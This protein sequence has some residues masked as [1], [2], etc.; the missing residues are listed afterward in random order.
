MRVSRAKA[1]DAMHVDL[2]SAKEWSGG[3]VR[4]STVDGG[5]PGNGSL[6]RYDVNAAAGLKTSLTLQTTTW[7]PPQ[8]IAGTFV[9]GPIRGTWS[10]SYADEDGATRVT[11]AMDYELP[12]LLRLTGRLFRSQYAAGIRQGMEAVRDWLERPP[13]DGGAERPKRISR[14]PASQG[15]DL[16]HNG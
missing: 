13:P 3:Q 14:R 4:L 16:T 1:W 6:V 10:Y 9:E 8:R 15:E 11:Y 2:A 12:G 5:P 7:E